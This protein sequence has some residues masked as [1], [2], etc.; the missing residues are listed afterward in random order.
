MKQQ[1]KKLWEL[2]GISKSMITKSKAKADN[3]KYLLSVPNLDD[4][5]TNSQRSLN[6]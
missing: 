3:S 1:K 6:E 2:K 5:E 4:E